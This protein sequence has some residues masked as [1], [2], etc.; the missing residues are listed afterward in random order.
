MEE[1]M[2]NII[3]C[4]KFANLLIF[5]LLMC[6]CISGKNMA[7][8]ARIFLLSVHENFLKKII[9]HFNAYATIS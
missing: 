3:G 5:K 1:Q 8:N 4:I 7:T 6:S 2:T 9:I